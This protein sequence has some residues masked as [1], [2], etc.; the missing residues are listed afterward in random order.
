MKTLE[1]Q[2]LNLCIQSAVYIVQAAST[3]ADTT[4]AAS[5]S[6]SCIDCSRLLGIGIEEY[7]RDTEKRSRKGAKARLSS[8]FDSSAA[9][10]PSTRLLGVV[11]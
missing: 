5:L 4:A 6:I 10:T 3:V 2:F 11:S 8:L 7:R 1:K 9:T